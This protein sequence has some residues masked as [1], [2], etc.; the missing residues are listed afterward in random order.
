MMVMGSAMIY[1]TR[2]VKFNNKAKLPKN[3]QARDIAFKMISL[4]LS[5]SKSNPEVSGLHRLTNAGLE[6]L[7]RHRPF[8]QATVHYSGVLLSIS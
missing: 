5:I 4:Q 7:H 1:L 8:P 6:Y 3:P 2:L